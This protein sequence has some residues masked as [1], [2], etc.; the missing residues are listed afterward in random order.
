MIYNCLN[1]YLKISAAT[2]VCAGFSFM[3][4]NIVK[5]VFAAKFKDIFDFKGAYIF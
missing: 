5:A 3:L 2:G 4:L 1:H